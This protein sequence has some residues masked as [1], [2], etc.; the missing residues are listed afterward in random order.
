[1]NPRLLFFLLIIS[2][3]SKLSAQSGGVIFKVGLIYNDYLRD[4]RSILKK[5]QVGN[6]AGLEIRLGAYDNTYFKFSGYYASLHYDLQNHPKETEFFNV[7]NGYQLIK[8]AGGIE[9]RLVTARNFNWRLAAMGA[10]SFLSGVRGTVVREDLS[11]GIFGVHVS[12]GFDL[13]VFSIDLA[14]EP[15]LTDFLK[16]VENTRPFI[17]MLTMGLHL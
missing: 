6:T 8:T 15:G 5:S 4:E 16:A 11:R 7:I 14:I 12:S 9:G 1:M 17:M 13:S 10:F 3:L 2:F